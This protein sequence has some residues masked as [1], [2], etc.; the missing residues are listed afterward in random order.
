MPHSI[1]GPRREASEDVQG[2]YRG[3]PLAPA[4]A[5][6][7]ASWTTLETV[8][9]LPPAL[10]ATHNGTALQLQLQPPPSA[11]AWGATVWLG[12]ASIVEV[13]TEPQ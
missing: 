10:N 2:V 3:T 4:V 5:P 7:G 8:L 1:L 12:A 9:R 6:C 11:R 13:K